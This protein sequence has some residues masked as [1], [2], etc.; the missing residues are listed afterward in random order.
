MSSGRG[1]SSPAGGM[2]LSRI[3]T[4][5]S[6]GGGGGQTHRTAFGEKV[7]GSSQDELMENIVKI[8]DIVIL[9]TEECGAR[10]NG[11]DSRGGRLEA[12]GFAD[13]GCWVREGAEGGGETFIDS[14]YRVKTKQVRP[15]SLSNRSKPLSTPFC[16]NFCPKRKGSESRRSSVPFSLGLATMESPHSHIACNQEIDLKHAR[17]FVGTNT[18]LS[19]LPGYRLSPILLLL[20]LLFLLLVG[21]YTWLA[22]P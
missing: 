22:K 9:S 3:G 13:G 2:G 19:K 17:T 5:T 18:P 10:W 15:N 4:T 12:D 8:G 16:W 20:L 21:R 1:T 6:G 14:L 7:V 11:G